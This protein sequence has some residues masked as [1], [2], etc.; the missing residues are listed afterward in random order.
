MRRCDKLGVGLILSEGVAEDG[1]G[2]AIMNRMRKAAG[3]QVLGADEM[4][5]LLKNSTQ[6]KSFVL[7]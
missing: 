1:L 6:L 3:R 4:Q 5:E 7:K 2:L